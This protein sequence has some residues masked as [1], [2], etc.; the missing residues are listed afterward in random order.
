M[1]ELAVR[2]KAHWGYSDTFLAACREE[3]TV[4]V[5]DI[6]HPEKTYVVCE[7]NGIVVGFFAV[8]PVSEVQYELEALFV[9]PEHIGHGY[10]RRLVEQ[11]KVIVRQSGARSMLIQGDP[12]AEPFYTAMGAVKTGERES[13][14][15]P[16]RWLPEFLIDL[17]EAVQ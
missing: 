5:D 17:T 11:A 4:T 10:G 7:V 2:S 15:I 6:G 13:A 9:A 14:S 8:E 16:G 3:L 1:S 12:N